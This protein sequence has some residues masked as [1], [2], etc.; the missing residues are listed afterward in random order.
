M[1]AVTTDNPLLLP[2]L[3]RLDTSQSRP[4]P[5]ARVGTA[6]RQREGAGFEVRRPF[7][8]PLSLAAADPFLLF[9]HIGPQNNPPNGT[10]GAP[11][12]PHRG[13]ETV[14]YVMDGE[15]AH[16]DTNGGGGVIGE[17][18]TQWMTAG[19]GILHDEL[20]TERMY[21]RGGPMHVV[22][23]W[24]NLPAS[25]KLT[26]ARYQA[27]P[28]RALTMLASDDGGALIRLIAGELSGL[29]GPGVTPH[30][31]HI[32]PRHLGARKLDHR[33][34]ARSLQRLHLRPH[35]PWLRGCREGVHPRRPAGRLRSR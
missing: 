18:D 14:T 10:V 1:P 31:D 21:R 8:G 3:P 9:D 7:P 26:A 29:T 34:L 30:T 32:R 15:I 2:R 28:A 17:G 22:Q 5:V 16:H 24:V 27:L 4:R 6:H 35:R 25:H 19:G 33:P 23:L 11:W 20:P 12:H 13:F